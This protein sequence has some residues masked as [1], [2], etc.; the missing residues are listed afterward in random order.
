MPIDYK[1]RKKRYGNALG[2][3]AK[4]RKTKG[5]RPKFTSAR[6]NTVH[7]V[8]TGS[9]YKYKAKKPLTPKQYINKLID[10]KLMSLTNN[11][12]LSK[13]ES[14][15]IAFASNDRQILTTRTHTY[16]YTGG[17]S[18]NMDINSQFVQY[19]ATYKNSAKF[20]AGSTSESA[21]DFA[22]INLNQFKRTTDPPLVWYQKS[23]SLYK[24]Y[25]NNTT[26]TVDVHA[27]VFRARRLLKT[28][29][30]EI[31]SLMEE[32][33]CSDEDGR[34]NIASGSLIDSFQVLPHNCPLIK[35]Y[36][37]LEQQVVKQ[38]QP[39]DEMSITAKCGS[40]YISLPKLQSDCEELGAA[41]Y[42]RRGDKI[43]WF[44]V[45]GG[46]AHD[47]N[48][49]S[50]VGPAGVNS[51]DGIDSLSRKVSVGCLKPITGYTHYRFFN[52]M[53]TIPINNSEQSGPA[54]G[55]HAH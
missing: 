38:L 8:G 20:A 46:I 14:F 47:K 43:V 54:A 11:L 45:N 50:T 5:S 3:I 21:V 40:R 55:Q 24:K 33:Y 48:A 44:C 2:R 25:R 36:Y 12:V 10:K 37:V 28:G 39:G 17:A 42:M 7:Y 16:T 35:K 22:D 41:P 1:Q 15:N 4:R 18:P 13:S 19:Q 30:H 27:Y 52:N 49:K 29:L 53:D 9:V 32:Y 6:G 51:Q 23:V 26:L 31:T 34:S